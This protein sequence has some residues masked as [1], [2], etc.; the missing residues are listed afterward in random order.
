M[1]LTIGMPPMPTLTADEVVT[2]TRQHV[3]DVATEMESRGWTIT[4]GGGRFPEDYLPGP[5][6]GRLGSSHPD[7]TATKHG[8]TLRINTIDT[9]AGGTPTPREAGNAARIR[10]QT[11]VTTCCLCQNHERTHG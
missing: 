5:G 6:G 9:R 3:S 7:I 11:P 2:G 10:S 1:V 8:R 4:R